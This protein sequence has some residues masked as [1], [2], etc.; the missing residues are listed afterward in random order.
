MVNYTNDWWTTNSPKCKAT[1]SFAQCFLQSID[2][3][4]Q[5]CI[6]IT[7]GSCPPPSWPDFKS[8]K[9]DVRQFYI[10]YNIYAIWEFYNSYHFALTDANGLSSD[11]I[12]AIVALLDPPKP[13]NGLLDDLLTVLSVG[14]AMIEPR[15]SV[16]IK[17]LLGAFKQIPQT[18]RFMFPQGTIDTQVTQWQMLANEM[19]VVTQTLQSNVSQALNLIQGN[20]TV[21]LAVTESGSFSTNPVQ[22]ITNASSLFLRALNTYVISQALTGNGWMIARAIDTDMNALMSNKTEINW[23]VAGCGKGYDENNLCGAYYYNNAS[24]RSFT[25]TNNKDGS[26]DPTHIMQTIF[27]NWTTPELLFNGA[28]QCQ[29]QGGNLPTPS[30]GDDGSLLDPC[31]SSMKV[32]TWYSSPVASLLATILS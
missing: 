6:G 4:T 13:K 15:A 30:F 14:F 23:Q 1:T 21:W 25:L 17:S 7:S 26:K 16:L 29:A 5:D 28:A 2:L 12:G 31:L 22:T 3:G 10:A 32:C 8:R 27:H 24:A 20:V 18:A 11:T 9:L 19:G